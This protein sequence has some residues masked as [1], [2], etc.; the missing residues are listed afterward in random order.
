MLLGLGGELCMGV[1][2][3]SVGKHA[4]GGDGEEDDGG[5]FRDTTCHTEPIV[6]APAR[7]ASPDLIAAD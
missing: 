1:A 3:P 6:E 4:D 7:W 2:T 5:G